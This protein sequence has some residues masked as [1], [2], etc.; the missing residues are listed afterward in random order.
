MT[1]MYE[2]KAQVFEGK[3]DPFPHAERPAVRN[4]DDRSLVSCFSL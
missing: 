3:L 1:D 4:S 2:D